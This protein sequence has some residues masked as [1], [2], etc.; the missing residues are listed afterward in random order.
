MLSDISNT[1]FRWKYISN[2]NLKLLPAVDIQTA[3]AVISMRETENTNVDRSKSSAENVTGQT[4]RRDILRRAGQIGALSFLTAAAPSV[5]GAATSRAVSRKPDTKFDPNNKTEVA[6]FI[7]DSFQ[8]GEEI[9]ASRGG[10]EVTVE[11]ANVRGVL[12][13]DRQR[14]LQDLTPPATTTIP[15]GS[16]GGDARPPGTAS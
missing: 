9:K 8:R 1:H 3:A 6:E 16:G 15:G 2:R 14:V 4:R 5:V 13:D 12:E 10:E 7:H 11:A